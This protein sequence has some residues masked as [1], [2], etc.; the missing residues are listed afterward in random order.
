[1]PVP[2]EMKKADRFIC[3]K[4]LKVVTILGYYGRRL[5]GPCGSVLLL[6]FTPAATAARSYRV[7]SL[8]V[9]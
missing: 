2:S 3:A 8:S 5:S 6:I 9:R 1:M 4:G 7:R